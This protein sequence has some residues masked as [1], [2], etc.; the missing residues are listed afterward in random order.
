MK[1]HKKQYVRSHGIISLFMLIGCTAMVCLP[2]WSGR[3][4]VYQQKTLHRA[5][6]LAYQL[7][8]GRKSASPAS[9]GRGPASVEGS[10]NQLT[11]EQGEIGLDPWGHP[12]QYKLLKPTN[13]QP[14][15]ILVW[16]LGPNG[17]A[18]TKDQTLDQ[19][20][21]KANPEFSGDDLGIMLS[22]K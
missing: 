15:K 19:N 22:V 4:G 17:Q 21:D 1:E 10:L 18:E 20:R 7:L 3:S 8:D 13:N 12:F 2:V 9:A 5:E 16:S 6:S 14:T 11:K